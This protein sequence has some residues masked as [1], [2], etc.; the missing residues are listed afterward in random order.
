MFFK[1]SMASQL[2][3]DQRGQSM[4]EYTILVAVVFVFLMGIYGGFRESF[5]VY[6]DRILLLMA[7]PFP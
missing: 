6:L 3:A 2:V 1:P 4:T 5:K 7:L